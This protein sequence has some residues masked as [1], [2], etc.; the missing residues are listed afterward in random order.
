MARLYMVRHGRAAAGFDTADPGL[1]E[2]GRSQAEGA[3]KTLEALGPLPIL[4]S[5]LLRTRETSLPLARTWKCE[6]SVEAAIAEIPT[7]THLNTTNRVPWLRQFMADTWRAAGPELAEWRERVLAT[8]TAIPRDTVLFSHFIAINVGVG[9]AVGDD[10]VVVFSPDN[11]SITIFESDGA[12]L[13]LVQRGH[14]ATTK[15]N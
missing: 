1:D 7:P 13:R 9:K 3:A 6:P 14:E 8:L 2:V 10:R 11:C 15:V 4:T 5:P 12:D